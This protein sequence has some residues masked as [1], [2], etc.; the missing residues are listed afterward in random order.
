MLAIKGKLPQI[1]KWMRRNRIMLVVAT[2][3]TLIVYAGL[4]PPFPRIFLMNYKMFWLPFFALFRTLLQ[5]VVTRI[6]YVDDFSGGG[7]DL[8]LIEGCA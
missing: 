8:Y 4:M 1:R 6:V 7:I 2:V 5:I 3:V